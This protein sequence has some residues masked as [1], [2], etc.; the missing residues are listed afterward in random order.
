MANKVQEVAVSEG[1]STAEQV[2]AEQLEAPRFI[3]PHPLVAF[4]EVPAICAVQS[5]HGVASHVFDPQRPQFLAETAS[6]ALESSEVEVESSSTEGA[7]GIPA[8]AASAS[9]K[10]P[11]VEAESPSAE[12][13][14]NIPTQKPRPESAVGFDIESRK[15]RNRQSLPTFS[16][17][18][19]RNV[20][21]SSN[22]TLVWSPAGP[23][24]AS[25]PISSEF[26]QML[27]DAYSQIIG[28]K[29]I[30]WVQELEQVNADLTQRLAT[31][32]ERAKGL[33]TDLENC[34]RGRELNF[35]IAL[36]LYRN[37]GNLVLL[38]RRNLF[39]QIEQLKSEV[40][41][42]DW[43]IWSQDQ[44]IVALQLDL[45]LYASQGHWLRMQQG[46]Q[47]LTYQY[48]QMP[49]HLRNLEQQYVDLEDRHINV[50]NMFR[51]LDGDHT[52]LKVQLDMVRDERNRLEDNAAEAAEE[53]WALKVQRD[54][55]IDQKAESERTARANEQFLA[56]LAARMFKQ[57]MCIA[58]ILEDNGINPMDNEQIALYQLAYNYLGLDA[59][60]ISNEL[61]NARDEHDESNVPD[62]NA[63][64][65][66][67][68]M[69][70]SK[71]Y[72]EPTIPIAG[73][74]DSSNIAPTAGKGVI[75]S[76]DS[77]DAR[78]RHEVAAAE[79]KILGPL[80]LGFEDGS[81]TLKSKPIPQSSK[82]AKV[83]KFMGLF[84]KSP[85]TP[86]KIGAS[87]VGSGAG[88]IDQVTPARTGGTGGI[89][90]DQWATAGDDLRAFTEVFGGPRAQPIDVLSPDSETKGEEN[91][92][93]FQE[94]NSFQDSEGPILSTHEDM[95]HGNGVA[96]ELGSGSGLDVGE[97]GV[98]LEG[99]NGETGG[100]EDGTDGEINIDNQIATSSPPPKNGKG[101]SSDILEDV[102]S[103]IDKQE[104]TFSDFQDPFTISPATAIEPESSSGSA[105]SES[106]P[107]TP[108]SGEGSP[109][110]QGLEEGNEA[111]NEEAS[112][113]PSLP[114]EVFNAPRFEDFDFGGSSSG[115][116][117]TG[118]KV[119]PTSE[120]T[121]TGLFNLSS[122]SIA[123]APMTAH[124]PPRFEQD[125]NFS[126][127][128]SQVSFT[129]SQT[130][131]SRPPAVAPMLESVGVSSPLATSSAQNSPSM[132]PQAEEDAS[133]S[134][135][136][137]N[138]NKTKGK[139]AK[140]ESAPTIPNRSQRRAASRERKAAEK[141]AQAAAKDA[142]RRGRMV[143]A[144]ELIGG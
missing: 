81:P 137:N 32:T 15:R 23:S 118:S 37:S 93:R 75:E 120:P 71:S 30:D 70:T 2:P 60:Q 125:F 67:S 16:A 89:A 52:E 39:E 123:Q 21:N 73:T 28:E 126:G 7:L 13:S 17:S 78:R 51:N 143:V 19:S 129:A 109:I 10:A 58:D 46:F 83:S 55:I 72:H 5:N 131:S 113:I 105:T 9:Q 49:Q 133:K 88:E 138:N 54:R 64:E 8:Q 100:S 87:L 66:S 50:C 141:K 94:E 139:N 31:Q 110:F 56:G 130:T 20:S 97:D 128:N 124:G 61:D 114:K 106:S 116:P 102:S 135:N 69:S 59:A 144:R 57:L 6:L 98:V 68:S 84:P 86:S 3:S 47:I 95:V 127:S 77:F 79:E 14:L 33:K 140:E 40:L 132:I 136:P 101:K 134:N 11:E 41:N 63:G 121:S 117:F 29:L 119:E 43:H 35:N 90:R 25:S 80:G 24:S 22:D 1:S 4:T 45:H 142:A 85:A 111:T 27:Q 65:G 38:E 12:E 53:H 34:E 108:P 74:N 36:R 92:S 91:G 99:E 18:H 96:E 104:P 115:V 62:N 112:D 42:R 26:G 44:L 82:S 48:G 107:E 122:A 76:P 103:G